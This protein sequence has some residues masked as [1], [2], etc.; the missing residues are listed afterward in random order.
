MYLA[1]P[2]RALAL[3]TARAPTRVE[4][5]RVLAQSACT[6][7][8]NHEGARLDQPALHQ[9]ASLFTTLSLAL[10][11]FHFFNGFTSSSTL[12]L[13]RCIRSYVSIDVSIHLTAQSLFRAGL[14]LVTT[15]NLFANG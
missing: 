9:A 5:F 1:I 15:A 4:E 8:G 6:M 14:T 13:H 2:H 7:L 11:S 3:D 12:S 10:L